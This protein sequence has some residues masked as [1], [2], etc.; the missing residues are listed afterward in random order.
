[1]TGK[2]YA[3]V[4][5]DASGRTIEVDAG[6]GAEQMISGFATTLQLRIPWV[7]CGYSDELRNLYRKSRRDFADAVRARRIEYLKKTAAEAAEAWASCHG[8]WPSF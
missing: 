2:T 6:R 7:A 1:M 4:I 5:H 8:G 3:I